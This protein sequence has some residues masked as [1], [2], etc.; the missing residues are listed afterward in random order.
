MIIGKKMCERRTDRGNVFLV[1]GDDCVPRID[2]ED[3]NCI[4]YIYDT[5][6][7]AK[8]GARTGG[9]G[10]LVRHPSIDPSVDFGYIVT[11]RHIIKG[12]KIKGI[13][14]A[15]VVRLNTID[16]KVDCL[17]IRE[18]DWISK[19]NCD[20]AACQ[21]SFR[22]LHQYR[23]NSIPIGRFLTPEI[24]KDEFIGPGDEIYML[25][26]FVNHEGRQQNTPC[27]R[28]GFLAMMP[29]EPIYHPSNQPREQ[30][31]FLADIKSI[32]GYS[33]SPVFVFDLR[34][35][36]F[37]SNIF[38]RLP[39]PPWLLGID[40][41]NILDQKE[42]NTGLAGVVPAW[43]LLD[44]LNCPTFSEQRAI[45]NEQLQKTMDAS[46]TSQD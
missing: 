8:A 34:Y 14:P 23:L 30:I 38:Q 4:V 12:D 43:Y 46:S 3:L 29:G 32:A 16:G 5:V 10:F 27:A 20:L 19:D 41:G 1:L 28:F 17:P 37:G 33:G 6:D 13:Q 35:H 44:L 7:N 22:D 45:A 42:A 9:S 24:I 11:N 36:V 21:I 40:W 26:R 31:S 39:R 2:D 15:T 25:G 18:S